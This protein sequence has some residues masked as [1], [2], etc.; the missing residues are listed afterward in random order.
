MCPA[1][2]SSF[3]KTVIFSFPRLLPALHTVTLHCLNSMSGKERGRAHSKFRYIHFTVS[4]SHYSVLRLQT[5]TYSQ[6]GTLTRHFLASMSGTD[7]ITVLYCRFG[8]WNKERR[9]KAGLEGKKQ[10]QQQEE[11]REKEKKGAAPS[12]P[13]WGVT[14]GSPVGSELLLWTN[15]LDFKLKWPAKCQTGLDTHPPDT[16][17]Q[18]ESVR[19]VQLGRADVTP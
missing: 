15:W 7:S 4:V 3:L 6:R 9:G 12:A 14:G 18:Q 1:V 19:E 13:G 16:Q 2:L 17:G 8:G 5:L 11:M 10:Q